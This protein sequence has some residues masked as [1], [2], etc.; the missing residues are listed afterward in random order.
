VVDDLA[1]AERRTKP[2]AAGTTVG[3]R[4]ASLGWSSHGSAGSALGD[5]V[6]G[7]APGGRGHGRRRLPSG[8]CQ[9]PRRVVVADIAVI[10]PQAGGRERRSWVEAA[11]PS[12]PH[13]DEQGKGVAAALV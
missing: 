2:A 8:A 1:G 5:L 4:L 13:T 6:A 7:A 3:H 10:C 12:R 11:G 9:P